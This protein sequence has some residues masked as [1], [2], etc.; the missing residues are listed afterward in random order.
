M[1]KRSFT[2]LV[3]WAF[4]HAQHWRVRGRFK[5]LGSCEIFLNSKFHIYIYI[6]VISWEIHSQNFFFDETFFCLFTSKIID[7]YFFSMW[8]L[9]ISR[10]N[11]FNCGTR[12]T[13]FFHLLTVKAVLKIKCNPC[14]WNARKSTSFQKSYNTH[15]VIFL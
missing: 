1:T 9:K 5:D 11:F 6:C 7:T 15:F 10:Y 13:F 2:S 8:Y 14:T 3:T 12:E 4:L